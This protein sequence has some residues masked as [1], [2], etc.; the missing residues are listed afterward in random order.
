MWSPSHISSSIPHFPFAAS[1][2]IPSQSLRSVSLRLDPLFVEPSLVTSEPGAPGANASA[3]AGNGGKGARCCSA[4]K[5]PWERR[6]HAAGARFS[7]SNWKWPMGVTAARWER[8]GNRICENG[9]LAM[10]HL[11]IFKDM[12]RSHKLT[13]DRGFDHHWIPFVG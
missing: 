12:V 9:M 3:D 8:D 7:G 11:R 2:L 13:R 10:N 6:D 4:A 5:K 1:L